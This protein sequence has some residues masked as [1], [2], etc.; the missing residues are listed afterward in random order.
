MT[1]YHKAYKR[2]IQKY[3][4]TYKRLAK[5]LR[6]RRTYKQ[7]Q[8]DFDLLVADLR[9]SWVKCSNGDLNTSELDKITANLRKLRKMFKYNVISSNKAN[10]GVYNK[11]GVF[12][13]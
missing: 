12:K 9:Y 11:N 3:D 1:L 2:S 8:K 5:G 6:M 13:W 4:K 7:I 10:E